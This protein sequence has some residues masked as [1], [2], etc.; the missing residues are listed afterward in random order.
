M[1]SL[2]RRT[3]VAAAVAAGVL[4]GCDAAAN[5]DAI[6]RIKAGGTVKLGPGRFFPLDT[7]VPYGTRIEGV[8]KETELV[9]LRPDANLLRYTGAIALS[10]LSMIGAG[11]GSIPYSTGML[12]T[13]A[14]DVILDTVWQTGFGSYWNN[15]NG[16]LTARGVIATSAPGGLCGPQE[17]GE[18]RYISTVFQQYGSGVAD[19]RG[20]RGELAYA[21]NFLAVW[22]GGRGIVEDCEINDAGATAMDDAAAYAL[23]AY[24]YP[25][26]SP[27]AHPELRVKRTVIRRARSCGIYSASA[28]LVTV[29]DSEFEGIYVDRLTGTIP[30]GAIALNSTTT[31][32]LRGTNR[33]SDNWIDINVATPQIRNVVYGN[34]R[35]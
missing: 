20:C 15:V 24:H 29:D 25:Y 35:D 19:V 21:K 17:V 30:K 34:H 13:G 26:D 22:A 32:E 4:A 5:E 27:H 1:R 10:N 31:F 6:A 2:D 14:G 12:L 23:L 33:F 18:T 8:G 28:G 16:N 11:P 3:F 9:L 7:D